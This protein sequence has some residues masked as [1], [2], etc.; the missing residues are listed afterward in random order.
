MGENKRDIGLETLLYLHEHPGSTTTDIAKA[1][2]DPDGIDDMRKKDVKVR[3]YLEKKYSPI[4]KSEKEN[5]KKRYSID[6]DRFY[7]GVGK[8]DIQTD[9]GEDISIGLGSV[10]LLQDGEGR[11]TVVNLS[12]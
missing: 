3:Y 9:T 11:P 7:L 2:L 4:V 12:S 10:L 8:I 5:G 6:E 1:V